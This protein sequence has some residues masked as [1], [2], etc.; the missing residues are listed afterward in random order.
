MMKKVSRAII[1]NEQGLV[2]LGKRARGMGEDKYALIGGKLDEG[3]TP[4]EAI[5]REVKEE[6]GL[7]FEPTLFL[8]RIDNETDSQNPWKVYFFTG[9]V[10]GK[11][12]LNKEEINDIIFI[13]EE[14]LDNLDI[15]FD[16]KDRLKDFFKQEAHAI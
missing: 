4:K 5:I 14:G 1:I 15:A 10:S 6:L 7:D 13:S 16:H 9:T 11:F 3:E 12:K 2:L 8:E